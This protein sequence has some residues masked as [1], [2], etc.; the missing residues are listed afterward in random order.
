MKNTFKE[1]LMFSYLV[2]QD[3][4]DSL[5]KFEPF[6]EELKHKGENTINTLEGW[7]ID[8]REIKD[9]V[10]DTIQLIKDQMEISEKIET[11]RNTLIKQDKEL[12]LKSKEL[13]HQSAGIP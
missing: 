2:L 5:E 10:D 6:S 11:R 4:H 13:N 1:D 8:D 12:F 7:N 9:F 3:M